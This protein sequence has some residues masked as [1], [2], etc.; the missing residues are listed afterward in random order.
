MTSS[1]EGTVWDMSDITLPSRWSLLLRSLA[2]PT[3][4]GVVAGSVAAVVV[5]HRP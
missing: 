5:P 2:V 3:L 4:A 1:Q